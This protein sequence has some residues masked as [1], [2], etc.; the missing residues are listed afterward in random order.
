MTKE[1]NLENRGLKQDAFF[2]L[3][4]ASMPSVLIETGFLSNKADAAYLKSDKGQSEISKAIYKS[5]IYYKMDYDFE[6]NIL[7]K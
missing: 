1:T 6:N 4:G 5:I 7:F 2:V 3:V